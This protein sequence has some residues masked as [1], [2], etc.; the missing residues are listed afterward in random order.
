MGEAAPVEEEALGSREET[1]RRAEKR[2]T[3]RPKRRKARAPRNPE[4]WRLSSKTLVIEAVLTNSKMRL[5]EKVMVTVDEV[6]GRSK[7]QKKRLLS[8]K[9]SEL[10]MERKR[11]VAVAVAVAAVGVAEP[12]AATRREGNGRI[13]SGAPACGVVQQKLS[14]WEEKFEGEVSLH[15]SVAAAGQPIH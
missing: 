6:A 11:F 9:R 2:T 10:E 12:E 1:K 3:H 5:K 15:R 14:R 7:K 13:E 4:S 8:T